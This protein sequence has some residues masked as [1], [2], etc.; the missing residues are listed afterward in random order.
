MQDTQEK[1]NL[2]IVQKAGIE[3]KQLLL[4]L[5]HNRRRHFFYQAFACVASKSM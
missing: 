3:G 2:F 4:N 5:I 1:Q